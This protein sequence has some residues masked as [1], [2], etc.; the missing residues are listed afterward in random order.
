MR[1]VYSTGHNKRIWKVLC[2]DGGKIKAEE[3]LKKLSLGRCNWLP[4]ECDELLFKE[5]KR[6]SPAGAIK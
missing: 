5:E 1:D 3:M 6:R 2:T 4:P